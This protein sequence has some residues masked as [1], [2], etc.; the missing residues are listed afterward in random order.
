MNEPFIIPEKFR[1]TLIAS[2]VK[3]L[4]SNGE[5]FERKVA[6]LGTIERWCVTLITRIHSPAS[7][8]NGAAHSLRYDDPDFQMFIY[9]LK[10]WVEDYHDF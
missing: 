2:E 4:L 3:K 7:R 9:A 8:V 1:G 6:R 10:Q 5:S